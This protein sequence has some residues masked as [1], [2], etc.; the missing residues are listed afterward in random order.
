MKKSGKMKKRRAFSDLLFFVVVLFLGFASFISY[1]QI[2]KHNQA[3]TLV[4]HANMIRFKLGEALTLLRAAE[5]KEQDSIRAGNLA[6]ANHLEKD[7]LLAYQLLD[8]LDSLVKEDKNQHAEILKVSALIRKWLD[9]LENEHR[10][11]ERSSSDLSDFSLEGQAIMSRIQFLFI[12]MRHA[13]DD[14]LL[15]K[16]QEKDRTAFLIPLFSMIFSFIAILLITG[17]FFRLRSETRLRKQAE[18]EQ[19]VIHN[20]FQQAPAMLAILKGPEHVFEF[21]N[22]SFRD[23]I[24]GRNPVDLPVREA[25][26]SATGQGYFEILDSVYKTGNP[27]VGKEMPLQVRRG[28]SMESIFINII[29]Q[30]LKNSSGETDGV[31]VF[32][33]DVSEQVLAR[34]QLQDLESRSRLGI[35]AARMGT[36]D[37]DLQNQRFISSERLVEIFGY[38]NAPQVSH[39]DLINRFLPGDK[40]IRDA[41]VQK[42]YQTGSLTYEARIRWAD[43][44]IHWINVYGKIFSDDSRNILR[45][46]G[47]VVDV[48]P[49]KIALEEIKESEAKFRLLANAMPQMIWTADKNGN[50]NYFNQAVYDYTGLEFKEI[51]NSGW[52][53]NIVHP[54]DRDLN[55]KK[56]A[57]SLRTGKEF[58]IEHRFK[59]ING[60]YRWQLSRAIPQKDNQDS[61]QMWI[62][63][64]TDIQEQKHFMQELEKSVAER[65]QSLNYANMVLKQTITELEQSN[66]ELAS[67]NYIASHDLQ[68]PLRKIIAFSKRIEDLDQTSLSDLSKDYFHRIISATS[69]M[70]NLIDAFLSYSQSSN[71]SAV[72][73]TADLNIILNEVRADFTE[74]IEQNNIILDCRHLPV[75]TCIPLQV[76]QLFTNLIGNAIKYRRQEAQ[77]KIEIFAEELNGSR[78]SFEGADAKMPYWKISIRDNGIGFDQTYES[79]IFELFQR[80]HKRHEYA[81]TGIGLAICKKIMRN[82]KGFIEAYGNSGTGSVFSVYFPSLFED[83]VYQDHNH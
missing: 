35:E 74:T 77:C 66:A 17:T 49:Q 47:T 29:C 34:T 20:F 51:A 65:T 79:Q 58:I 75:L 22:Q 52:L 15:E 19:A 72:F 42:S 38:H 7:S 39:Q 59:N 27:F 26:P 61:I 55:I 43:Q 45:M 53:I 40:P 81:G 56:W 31:L 21:L 12:E 69:R 48:T 10:K 50:L 11:V 62:G 41:A 9:N 37:W 46:Y 63:S 78:L 3:S 71:I 57:T 67:F 68:E 54:E 23:L 6:F 73:E 13:Q 1:Q 32:C 25:F 33:Y 28:D 70:Q 83:Y 44:S 76:N 30:V 18:G 8:N 60:D 24:G 2:T 80:L 4:A 16:I 82:H 5:K 64:S 36:F 14:M